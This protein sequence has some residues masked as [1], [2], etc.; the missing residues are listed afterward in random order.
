MTRYNA[1][2]DAVKGLRAALDT[3]TAQQLD[4]FAAAENEIVV[5]LERLDQME[6]ACR[7]EV[8]RCNQALRN[9]YAMQL[10]TQ[11]DCAAEII[12]LR[13]AEEKLTQLVVMQTRVQDALIGYRAARE[14]YASVLENELPRARGY[15]NDRITALEAYGSA[16]VSSSGA[17][18]G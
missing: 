17:Q 6:D 11:M 3:F 16:T 15:L 12:A 1:D 5:T 2:L 7:S 9:C 4:A 10:V 13:E 8:E 18:K 14:R